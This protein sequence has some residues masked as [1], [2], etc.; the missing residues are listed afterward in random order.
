MGKAISQAAHEQYNAKHYPGTRQMCIKC[1]T[2]TGRCEEDA[3]YTGDEY[4]PLCE[5]CYNETEEANTNNDLYHKG[6][7]K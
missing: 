1:Y 7:M 4:G 5:I 6:R 3:L 2:P